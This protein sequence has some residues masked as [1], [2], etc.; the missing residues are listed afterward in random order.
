MITMSLTVKEDK[1]LKTLS[2]CLVSSMR[3]CHVY[4]PRPKLDSQSMALCKS[5]KKSDIDKF[6]K[7]DQ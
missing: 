7:E 1:N 3:L 2:N 6:Y 5:M 4:C